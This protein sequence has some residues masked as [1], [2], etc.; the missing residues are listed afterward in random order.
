MKGVSRIFVL[1]LGVLLLAGSLFA[2]SPSLGKI[3][4]PTSGSAEAQ[5]HFLEGVLFLHNF[6][7][8]DSV[9]AFRR[10]Q[11]LD[12]DF[13]MAYW[14]EAMAHNHPLWR[15]VNVEAGR[16]ALN[17]LASTPKARLAKAPT[18]REKM[19][20]AAVEHLYGADG[21]TARDDA[22]SRSM[23]R[24]H[25]KYPDDLEAASFYSLSLLRL[26]NGTRDFRNYMRAAAVAEEVF[27]KNP[28]H[29][30][31]AH[32]LIH[33][34]DD[35]VHAPLGLRPARVYARI[36]PSA[37][38][39]QHMVSHIF[40]ALGMWDDMVKAN[41][42]SFAVADER[43]RRKGLGVDQ[44]NFHAL[45]WLHY[46]YLQQGRREK[47][48]EVLARMA[49]DTQKSGSLR[50]RTYLALMRSAHVVE[51]QQRNSVPPNTHLAGLSSNAASGNLFATGLRA[52]HSGNRPAAE[53]ALES[54][55]ALSGSDA[56]TIL[57]K[58]LE[59]LLLLDAGSA[60]FALT[61]LQEAAEIEDAMPFAF[62]PPVP[63]KPA[64]ELL[65]EVLL[66]LG[67]AQEART[68]FGKALERSP[69]RTLSLLGLAR[70]AQRSG[71]RETAQETYRILGK[72]WHQAD[73]NLPELAEVTKGMTETAR[74]K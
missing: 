54:M 47:A 29:P 2:Q 70:A 67:R 22:Y 17:R 42:I 55:K 26:T 53:K 37:S 11:K 46:G 21:K 33:S 31:A 12:P 40:V 44:R 39:A 72:I 48:R 7:F 9:E 5:K 51:T 73:A 27:A 4:F 43:V 15:E 16:A 28:M 13:A 58:E 10:A 38:H 68:E 20:L 52:L 45:Q 65:G 19:Y 56:G 34:Y 62:G 6:E 63:A 61:L 59:A 64:H 74:R 25:E 18:G 23:R 57:Q 49:A 69:L 24:I 36:A 14:G 50:A 71:D 30:G 8:E 60:N 3:D 35:P 32:Y 1:S 66:E 41:E